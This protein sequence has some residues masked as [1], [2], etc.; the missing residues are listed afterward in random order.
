MK[1]Y[2]GG[3]YES[4]RSISLKEEGKEK[5]RLT[6]QYAYGQGIFPVTYNELVA[7]LDKKSDS[8]G[9]ELRCNSPAKST[10][11]AREKVYITASFVRR[12]VLEWTGIALKKK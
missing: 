7:T 10:N 11:L 3:S 6:F 12:L 5:V 4:V 9:L 2:Y 8:Y 1:K